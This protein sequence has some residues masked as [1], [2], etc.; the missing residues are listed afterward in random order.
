VEQEFTIQNLGEADLTLSGNPPVVI[1]GDPYGQFVV[2]Q[3]PSTV[4][5]PGGTVSFLVDYV[6]LRI[7]QS[8]AQISIANNDQNE[9]PY[10]FTVTGCG[11]GGADKANEGTLRI[12]TPAGGEK[13]L[14][15]SIQ[16]IAWTGGESSEFVKLEFS[17]DNGTTY[18]AIAE[19]TPN[20]GLY[21]WQV[22]AEPLPSCLV[23]ISDPDG[24]RAVPRVLSVSFNIKLGRSSDEAVSDGHWGLRLNLPDWDTQISRI[25]EL[26]IFP[27][28]QGALGKA[29][30]NG[31]DSDLKDT[32]IP[33][34]PWHNIQIK[35][36]LEELSA[37]LLI[38]GRAILE[39]IPL[40]IG[41]IAATGPRIEVIRDLPRAIEAWM[42]DLEVELQGQTIKAPEEWPSI[43]SPIVRDMF[44]PYASGG[45]PA[46]GGW[47]VGE[48][49]PNEATAEGAPEAGQVVALATDPQGIFPAFID[50]SE[51]LSPL[52]A[53][54]LEQPEG[55]SCLIMKRIALPETIPYNISLSSFAITTGDV[56]IAPDEIDSSIEGNDVLSDAS[57]GV[58]EAGLDK[59]GLSV[60]AAESPAVE[61]GGTALMT[62]SDPRDGC[63]YIY[64]FDG[65]LLA[66]YDIYGECLKDYIYMGARLV[67]EYK[68][69]AAQYFYYSQDQI[70]STRV[71]TN[72][73]GAVV[74]AEAH[75]PYGGI[76]KTWVNTFD[77]KRKF[78]DKERDEETGLDYFGAR[79]YSA[80]VRWADGDSS[81]SY[82]WLSIDPVLDRSRA[83]TNPQLWNLYAFCADNPES[84]VDPKGSV[85]YVAQM[86]ESI[87]AIAGAAVGRLSIQ[88]GRL[89][90]SK[91]TDE[92]MKDPGVQLLVALA[93]S[94]YIFSYSEGISA[95]TAGG[96]CSVDGVLNLDDAPDWRYG[97]RKS[98][99]ALPP[100]GI[101]DLVV[102][103]PNRAWVDNSTRS[104]AVSFAAIAFHELAEAFYKIVFRIPYYEKG[105][106]PGAHL[107]ALSW[108]QRL[109]N[110]RN[111]FTSYPGGGSL[112]RLR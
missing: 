66:E 4:I 57:A 64:A 72:D 103:N 91:I 30:L 36:N 38:D 31:A 107:L 86:Y 68:P 90:V 80:P 3:Q 88:D 41:P 24:I 63:F 106:S 76:Q 61:T 105:G 32:E 97:S 62:L 15:G 84:F 42:D 22:P 111:G 19:R 59:I 34:S 53:L 9:N 10:H 17:P 46:L 82:R 110:Q 28:S 89:D 55:S 2:V 51:F 37:S 47:A 16:A 101:N 74:Y 75:D 23:R 44:D 87:K 78:S 54:K 77:P 52:K 109:I 73:A 20:T 95:M 43:D 50:D 100:L 1:T 6:A 108:E 83:I 85:L 40:T 7:G 26:A 49:V 65:R 92:D 79:Y 70:G 14:A 25:A 21:E 29:M 98:L 12:L 99:L 94:D 33:Q 58:A 104:I 93:E 5:P 45:F 96:E 112:Y 13:M 48:E 60:P 81:G 35:L 18:Q 11:E 71:V 27:D 69:A 67:A 102:I 8:Y 56:G 39:R